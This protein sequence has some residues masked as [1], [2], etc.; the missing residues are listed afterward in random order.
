MTQPEPRAGDQAR[1]TVLVAVSPEV[2][3]RVFT[4]EIDQW[5]RRG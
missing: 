5:S 1:A 2:A 3:Y 4:E